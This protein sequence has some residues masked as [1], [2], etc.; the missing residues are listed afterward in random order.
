MMTSFF[1]FF[2]YCG[3]ISQAWFVYTPKISVT[4]FSYAYTHKY[5][6]VCKCNIDF[7]LYVINNADL[8]TGMK[9]TQIIELYIN[10][11]IRYSWN[12]VN[13]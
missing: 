6:N 10:I 5:I 8:T 4:I 9:F 11:S 12:R 2:F 13:E 1:F 7:L 3:Q